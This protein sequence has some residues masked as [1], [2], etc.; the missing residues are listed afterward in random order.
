MVVFAVAAVVVTTF[1]LGV[2]YGDKIENK[3]KNKTLRKLF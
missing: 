1:L 3:N 2:Q